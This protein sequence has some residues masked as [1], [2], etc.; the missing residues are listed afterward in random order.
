M[1]VFSAVQDLIAQTVEA[2]AEEGALPKGLDLSRITAEPPRDASHGD[3]ASNAA[4][5]LSKAAGQKPRDLAEKL[6]EK[7]SQD[8]RVTSV[9]VAGPGFLNL[10]LA[11]SNWLEVV[12]AVLKAGSNFGDSKAGQ[13]TPVNVEYVSAN[14]TG[15]MHVGHGRGAVFGDALCALLEK[16]G[17][18]VTREYYVND[19]GVQIK[20]LAESV[21][22]RIR[23][24]RGQITQ[25][26][27]DAMVTAKE[28]EYGGDYL[29]PLAEEL[30]KQNSVVAALDDGQSPVSVLSSPAIEAMLALIREDL[31]ALGVTHDVFRS[32]KDIQDAGM[33]ANAVKTLEDKGLMYHGVLEPP[34]GKTPDDWEPREQYLFKAT[35]FGDDVDR[36]LQKSDGSWT[37]F[38]SDIAYHKDKFDRGFSEMINVF[39]ADHGG[40]VKRV[41]AALNAMTDGKGNLDVKLCQLVRVL[42]NGEPVRMSK[43]A[44]TFITLRDVIDRVGKDVVR[45]YMLTRKN[46]AQLDFDYARVVEKSKDN[47]VFYVQYAHARICSVLRHAA[48]VFPN[49]DLSDAAL[50]S[51][52]LSS[53]TDEDELGLVKLIA[54]WPRTVE[55]AAAAHEPHRLAFYLQD[56]AGAFHALWNKGNDNAELRFLQPDAEEAS[57]ARLALVRAVATVIASG[58]S[59]FGVTPVEEMR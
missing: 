11:P 46:D 39:G 23:V 35:E 22:Q 50:A 24:A 10:R 17:Y 28:I 16:A 26:D 6:A 12:G 29:V 8:D 41:Q 21:F 51:A 42:D 30:A 7:L 19:A 56:L 40:Y 43:R 1:N 25:Y 20:A 18:A 53:L 38:A 32:E 33:V 13:N 31:S 34:K 36:A 4:M 48:D 55:A 9:D 14:P 49:T 3:V 52:D 57:L 2:L 47:P 59:V 54:A 58:L 27:F 15:P 37:Y 5:V 44:G 45:F